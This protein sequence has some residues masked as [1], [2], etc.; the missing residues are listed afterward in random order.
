MKFPFWLLP[1]II[2]TIIIPMMDNKRKPQGDVSNKKIKRGFMFVFIGA[3]FL[4]V[5]IIIFLFLK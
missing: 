4:I 1:I 3:L 5:E 2:V